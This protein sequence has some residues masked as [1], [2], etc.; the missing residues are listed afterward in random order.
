[1]LALKITDVRDFT[2]KLF[3]G[4]VFD[5]FWLNE[6]SI[7]TFCTFSIDGKLQQDFFDSD[8]KELLAHNERNYALWKELK[9]HCFSIIRGKKTPLYFKI[10]FQLPPSQLSHAAHGT[11]LS[12]EVNGLFLNIQFKNNLLMCTTGTSLKTFIPGLKPDTLWDS[13]ILEFFHKNN[14]LFE[15]I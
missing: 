15:E 4:E 6:A 7:T 3:I 13:T 14:V 2:N 5:H 12:P 9:S 1:M 10:I 8:E 11:S